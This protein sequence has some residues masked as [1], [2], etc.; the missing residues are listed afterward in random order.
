MTNGVAKRR[1]GMRRP[2]RLRNLSLH[3][4]STGFITMF[5]AAG[6]LPTI[7]PMS[8]L[9]VPISLRVRGSTLGMRV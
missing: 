4:L 3:V 2:S 9:D 1:K 5:I 6:T 7:N 8:W